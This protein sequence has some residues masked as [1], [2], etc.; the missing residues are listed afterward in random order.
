MFH[1]RGFNNKIN[2]IH[3]RALRITNNEKSSSSQKLLE[4]NNSITIHPQKIK[5]LATKIY[6]FLQG[7]SSPLT[8]ETFVE[9]NSIYSLRGYHVLTRQSINSV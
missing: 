6:K 4:K 3:E 5:I 1:T 8:N 9:K 2:R 7:L